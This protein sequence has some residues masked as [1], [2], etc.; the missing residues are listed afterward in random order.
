MAAKDSAMASAGPLFT[1]LSVPKAADVLAADVRERILSGELAEGSALPSE[2][3]LVEQTG[4]SRATVREALRILTVEKL[5]RIRPGRGG[6]A[7]V[8]RPDH[9]SL[10]S[11]VQLVIRGQ[12][13]RLDA[14]HETREAVEPACAAL[15]AGRRTDAHLGE[16]DAAQNEL[17]DAGAEDDVPRFLRAN[18]RWH[19]VVARASGNELLI[20]FMNALA[21]SIYTATDIDRFLDDDIRRTTARAH[22]RVAR[23]IRDR[24]SAAAKRRMERHVCAFARAAEHI[25][26]RELLDLGND[27][28]EPLR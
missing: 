4:L 18:V 7:F 21:R 28:R 20:G 14:L 13:I 19:S 26:R 1:T 23:A 15:A 2:R 5:L 27:S 6:G 24:D 17:M 22:A 10:A 8:H 9:E 3:Q 12:H 11:T 25:D 16:L